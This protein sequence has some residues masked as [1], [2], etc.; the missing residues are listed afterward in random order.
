MMTAPAAAAIRDVAERRDERR[1]ARL[2]SVALPMI[3]VWS[4]SPAAS[5]DRDA[6]TRS[7]DPRMTRGP[8]AD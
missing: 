6:R 4:I 5:R 2:A 7:H 1:P 3:E 8:S